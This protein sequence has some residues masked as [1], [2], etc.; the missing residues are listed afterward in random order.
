M[1]SLSVLQQIIHNIIVPIVSS[2]LSS[3]SF[4]ASIWH[5]NTKMNFPTTFMLASCQLQR[6]NFLTQYTCCIHKLFPFRSQCCKDSIYLIKELLMFSITSPPNVTSPSTL[7]LPVEP[8]HFLHTKSTALLRHFHIPKH[9]QCSQL[10]IWYIK[11]SYFPLLFYK[12]SM[13][14]WKF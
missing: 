2:F 8:E 5:H 14:T 7:A 6:D 13:E 3:F 1:P 9:F 11:W 12:L 10:F 4:K